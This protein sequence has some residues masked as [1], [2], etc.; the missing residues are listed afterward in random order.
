MY[1]LYYGCRL[2]MDSSSSFHDFFN[3][4]PVTPCVGHDL[5]DLKV[6]GTGIHVDRLDNST[7]PN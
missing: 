5:G 1:V 4:R 3:N 7:F 2:G 6:E